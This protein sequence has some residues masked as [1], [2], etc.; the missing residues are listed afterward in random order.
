MNI[1]DSE[2]SR[3]R[4]YFHELLRRDSLESDWQ[5]FFATHPYVL[6]RGLPV[7]VEANDIVPL[8]RPGH[9]KPD[10]LFYPHRQA[11]IPSYGV[12]ELKRPQSKILSPPRSNVALLTRDAATAVEQAR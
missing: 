8:G 4:E 3:A 2:L 9:T 11:T 6:S 5:R 12:I 10:L 7:R 1:V